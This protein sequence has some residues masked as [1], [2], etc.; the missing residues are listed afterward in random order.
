MEDLNT[1]RGGTDKENPCRFGYRVRKLKS[2]PGSSQVCP[3]HIGKT[4]QYFQVCRLAAKL[5]IRQRLLELVHHKDF[6]L[7]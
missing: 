6:V 2:G 7:I 3:S 1:M 5:L 4:P